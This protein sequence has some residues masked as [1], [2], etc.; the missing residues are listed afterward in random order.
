M[1]YNK[2]KPAKAMPKI[3]QEKEAY[4]R[5]IVRDA[6]AIDPLITLE[7][8]RDVVER[9]IKRVIDLEYLSKLVKKIGRQIISE[10]ERDT[11]NN[12]VSEIRET[13]RI[14]I[15]ELKRI[16]YPNPNDPEKPSVTDRRKALEAIT[17]IENMQAKLEM[18]FN[19]FER[20]LGVVDVQ[21]RIKPVDPQTMVNMVKA[22]GAFMKPIQMRE[23][24]PESTRELKSAQTSN[25]TR[26][27]Q[28]KPN[29][30]GPKPIPA[31]I[32]AGVIATE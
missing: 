22:F 32:G 3:T 12:R 20:H 14:V 23:I 29:N 7:S 15:D 2:N 4:L 27:E 5:R 13:N 17:R 8:L 25:E 10:V 31:V 1:W 18:D 26:I 21:H 19:V 16:A 9:K 30:A 11:V 6:K 24:E 28:P